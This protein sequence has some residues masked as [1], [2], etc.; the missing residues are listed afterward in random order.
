MNIF[1]DLDGTL[2][3]SRKRLYFL[4]QHLVAES[5]FSFDEYWIFKR[6]KVSHREILIHQFNYSEDKVKEFEENW[7]KRIELPEWLALDSPF[8]GVFD[9]LNELKK[10]HKL[11]LVTARQSES[12][13]LKQV[14]EYG[15]MPIFEKILV[16]AQKQ[17]KFDLIVNTVEVKEHDWFVGDTGK[18][19]Q[20]GK[21]LGINTA[22]VLSGFLSRKRLLEY[23]PD[24]I[25]VDVTKL[26]FT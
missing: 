7:M 21:E 25:E 15:W 1:F 10:V 12:I 18:D 23:A 19:I 4:F 6:D 5:M 26:K 13:A 20:T 3:D 14:D 22:A 2:I 8:D 17:E 11:F 9:F 24:L 16:T